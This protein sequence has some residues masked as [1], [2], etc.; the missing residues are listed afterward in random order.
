MLAAWA[1]IA[2]VLTYSLYCTLWESSFQQATFGKMALSLEVT[3]VDQHRVSL[4]KAAVRNLAKLLSAPPMLMGF[5][6]SAY[7][8]RNQAF[9][10]IVA[11]CLVVV[12]D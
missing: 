10:D 5:V 8:P 1:G 3:D 2:S 9:H 11:R 12:R 4:R 6:I 7:T